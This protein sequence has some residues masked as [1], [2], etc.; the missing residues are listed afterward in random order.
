M[1]W[2]PPSGTGT[3]GGRGVGVTIVAGSGVTITGGSGVTIT[4]GS[5]VT[6]ALPPPAAGDGCGERTI[7]LPA[8][9]AASTPTTRRRVTTAIREDAGDSRRSAFMVTPSWC[10][11][12]G[13]W[14]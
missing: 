1:V 11:S 6:V 12:P 4:V 9:P 3:T 2:A 7:R 14:V 13:I 10:A 5:G 8:R